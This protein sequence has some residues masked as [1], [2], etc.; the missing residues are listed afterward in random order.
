[1]FTIACTTFKNG[2]HLCQTGEE[3]LYGSQYLHGRTSG[4]GSGLNWPCEVLCK[5]PLTPVELYSIVG[6]LTLLPVPQL[7]KLHYFT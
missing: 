5:H 2:Q 3:P 7:Q 4:I 6:S 1:M